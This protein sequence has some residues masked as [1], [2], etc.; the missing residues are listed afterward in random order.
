MTQET[1][2]I[3]GR[4]PVLELLRADRRKVRKVWL[5]RRARPSPPI[6]SIRKLAAA[7]Q[8][9]LR[10]VDHPVLDRLI[11]GGNHQGVVLEAES[12][13]Y[14][15]FRDLLGLVQAGAAPFWLLLDHIQDPQNLG[16]ILRSADAV[17][18]DAVLLPGQRAARITPAVVRVSAGAA[19]H[20]PIAIV[21]NLHQTM[22]DLQNRGFS[23]IGLETGATA[24]PYTEAD[25]RGGLGLVIGSEGQGIGR[26]I[27]DTCDRL[28]EIPMRGRVN[29]LNASAAAAVAMYEVLRQRGSRRSSAASDTD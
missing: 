15:E 21:G 7:R 19:E 25:L 1:E 28:I 6:K 3:Y 16:A 5:F 27:R 24:T 4:Q 20:L 29:S 17:G 18:V 14:C 23:M 12:Y 11:Q 26:Q 9:E 22:L 8:I 13:P 10:E 2:I